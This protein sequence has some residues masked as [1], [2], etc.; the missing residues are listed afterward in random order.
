VSDE[1]SAAVLEHKRT[2]RL[3]KADLKTAATTLTHEQVRYL[4][5]FYYEIQEARIRAGN[6]AGAAAE[7]EEPN[8]LVSWMQE[9]F[10]AVEGMIKS[11]MDAYTDAPN[12]VGAWLKELTGIGPILA[13]GL[14]AHVDI[15]RAPSAGH[16]WSFAGLEPK[17]RWTGKEESTKIVAE[18]LGPA[19]RGQAI[20]PEEMILL[21]ARCGRSTTGLEKASKNDKGVITRDS[22]IKGMSKRPWNTK[23][24]TLCWKIGQ[25]FVKTCNREDSFYGNF[26]KD[27]KAFELRKNEEHKNA[28]AAR[29][30]LETRNIKDADLRATYEDGKLPLAH[31]HAMTCRWVVKFFLSH[32]HVV[33]TYVRYGHLPGKPWVIVHGGHQKLVLPPNPHLIP[34]LDAALNEWR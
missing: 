2:L 27:R 23:L 16:I 18:I 30:A 9:E 19:K 26:Y 13:A 4:V 22:L 12:I 17:T 31:V 28:D 14:L 34:G 29:K 21:A 6:Q 8:A 10:E 32:L 1:S 7:D 20:G 3:L 15:T 24:K 5:D 11:A 25:S 33:M